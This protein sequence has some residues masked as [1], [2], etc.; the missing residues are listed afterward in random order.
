MAVKYGKQVET[1]RRLLLTVVIIETFETPAVSRPWYLF[2]EHC[3]PLGK[4]I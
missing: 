1:F 4:C 2:S 3:L